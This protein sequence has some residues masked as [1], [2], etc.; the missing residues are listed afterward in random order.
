MSQTPTVLDLIRSAV[1]AFPLRKANAA[2]LAAD[3]SSLI[4]FSLSRSDL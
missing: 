1:G 4:L 3:H 2:G